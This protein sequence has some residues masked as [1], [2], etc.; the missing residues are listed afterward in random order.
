MMRMKLSIMAVAS[1]LAGS[2]LAQKHVQATSQ[3]WVDKV[4]ITRSSHGLA[5]IKPFIKARLGALD[6]RIVEVGFR[7]Q[8]K[9]VTT[10]TRQPYTYPWTNRPAVS[11]HGNDYFGFEIAVG[12]DFHQASA[13]GPFYVK[14]DRGTYY[15]VKAKGGKDFTFD[16]NAFD[17]VVR[18]KGS[19]WQLDWTPATAVPT[20][21]KGGFGQYYNPY[22]NK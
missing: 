8:E 11:K 22:Q 20:Q 19:A 3:A 13:T 2:A 17:N 14:T 1:L 9:G 7:N 12:S 6:G 5:I 21:N 18:K 10:S 16:Q 15:W 4:G